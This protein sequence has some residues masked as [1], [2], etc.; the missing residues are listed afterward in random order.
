[1]K[2]LNSETVNEYM[3]IVEEFDKHLNSD[4]DATMDVIFNMPYPE[5]LKRTSPTMYAVELLH[6]LEAKNNGMTNE[7]MKERWPECP[8]FEVNNVDLWYLSENPNEANK[9]I[10]I[11][12]NQDTIDEII[13]Y[14][15]AAR[16]CLNG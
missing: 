13:E 2:A 9:R 15:Q 8:P 4:K 1:M 11:E 7:E 12:V 6:Y 14:F 3:E 10:T 5:V 16:E